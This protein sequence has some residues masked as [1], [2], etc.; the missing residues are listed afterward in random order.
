MFPNFI[1]V[2]LEFADFSVLESSFHCSK[3]GVVIAYPVFVRQ[4]NTFKFLKLKKKHKVWEKENREYY[5][6]KVAVLP[7]KYLKCLKKKDTTKDSF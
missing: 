2:G 4:L 7:I 5:S 6:K 1:S 3:K